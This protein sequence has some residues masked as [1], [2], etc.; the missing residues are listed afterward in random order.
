MTQHPADTDVR[1]D[2]TVVDALHRADLAR[3]RVGQSRAFRVLLLGQWAFAIVL[4]LTASPLSWSGATSTTNV[5]VYYAVFFG[6]LLTVVPT[7]LCTL[8][9]QWALTRHTFAVAQMLWSALLVHLTG[10]RIETHFHIFGSLAFLAFYRD[11]AV[12]VTATVVTALDHFIRAAVW[13]ES[14]YGIPDPE[15]WRSIEHAAWV[16]FEDVTLLVGIRMSL[17]EMRTL[18]RRRAELELVNQ[19][20]EQRVEERT[21]ELHASREQYRAL[22]EGTRSVPWVWQRDLRRFTYVGPQGPALLGCDVEEWL[23]PAFMADRLHPQDAEMFFAAVKQIT[24]ADVDIEH[25]L[26]RNDGGYVTVRS[27]ISGGEDSD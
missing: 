2:D 16:A 3:L 18:A 8:R 24:S 1:V 14:I 11:P 26:L 20:F 9:P 21:S 23:A 15:W 12:L 19:R 6:G 22:V 5:H 13:P 10:G 7:I 4:A 17:G 27:I 25:R